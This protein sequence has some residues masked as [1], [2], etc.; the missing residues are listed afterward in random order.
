VSVPT[1][2][3]IAQ[4]F[5]GELFVAIAVILCELGRRIIVDRARTTEKIAT[6]RQFGLAIAIAEKAVMANV[7]QPLWPNFLNRRVWAG[8]RAHE[9][10]FIV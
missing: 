6:S 5:T 7:L 4:R 3:T 10:V 2:R 9:I 1:G 8:W